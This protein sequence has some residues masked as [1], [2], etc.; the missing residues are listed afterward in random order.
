[1]KLYYGFLALVFSITNYSL[2]TELYLENKLLNMYFYNNISKDT[3]T[4]EDMLKVWSDSYLKK[5]QPD[6]QDTLN[7]QLKDNSQ[8]FFIVFNNNDY[9]IYK[10]RNYNSKITVIADFNTYSKIFKGEL[11]P[12]TSAGR[13]SMKK[14]APLDFKL[15]NGM[16]YQKIDWGRAYF[17]LINFFNHHP[18]NK[19]AIKKEY[20][21]EIHSG[22][23]IGLYYSEGYR[24]TYYFID[25]ADTLNKSGESD[26]YE[27]SIIIVKG[28]G[29]AKIGSDTLILN[30]NEAY[31]IRPN[32]EHKI[33][34]NSNQGISLL[35]NAWGEKAW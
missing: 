22:N 34:T 6:Y 16:T 12:Q 17:I 9:K 18:H 32:I 29:F 7:F 23:A 20:S 1:M 27:Q 33:W 4:F 26:P 31:Y 15:E 3:L 8:Y 28:T 19:I 11:S 25:K 30:E 21:R 35:W 14:P 13:S 5:I 10:E 24:S 2:V